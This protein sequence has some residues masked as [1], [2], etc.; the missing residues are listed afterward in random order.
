MK[1]KESQRIEIR[2]PLKKDKNQRAK[3]IQTQ[4]EYYREIKIVK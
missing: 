2:L 4:H 3:L 1:T